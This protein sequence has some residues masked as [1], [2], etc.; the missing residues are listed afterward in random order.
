[1]TEKVHIIE[2]LGET[3]LLLPVL[4]NTAL[5]ANDRAKYYFTLLQTARSQADRPLAHPVT[6]RAERLASGVTDESLDTT[7]ERAA[8]DPAGMYQIPKLAEVLAA[9]MRE[10]DLML[11]PVR[12]ESNG[13]AAEF[14]R[15]LSGLRVEPP[16]SDTVDGA[17]IEGMC[18]GSRDRG[19][20]LHLL[21]MD[22]HKALNRM[23]AR[24]ASE[25]LD[26]CL[27]YG[28]TD[29]DRPLVRAFMR[30]VNRT[31]P[32]KFDHP[33][34][35]TTATHSGARLVLQND[36]GTTDAHVL[37]IH[38]EDRTAAITCTDV[39][40]Q[41]L[42]F[43]QSLFERFTVEWDDTRSRKDTA[44]EQG[45]YHLSVG[46]YRAADRGGLE[47]FLEFLGSR[48]VF[49][50][51]WNRARKRLRN[52][53]RKGEAI[54]L[55]KWAADHDCGHMGFLKAGGELLLYETLQV[56]AR[57]QYHPGQS[58]EDLLGAKPADDYLKFVLRTCTEGLL[59]G[60]PEV[61]VRD[62]IRAELL[63]YVRTGQQSLFDI[64][65]D[66]AAYIVEIAQGLYTA[67]LRARQSPDP[68]P[69][70]ENARRAK[71]WESKA[72]AL[73]NQARQEAKAGEPSEFFCSLVETADDIADELE[74]AAFHLTLL[75][76]D[77]SQTRLYSSLQVLSEL[78]M[79]G[80]QEYLKAVETARHLHRSAARE[81]MG[82]FLDSI[83]RIMLVE[84]DADE[85]QRGVESALAQSSADFKA[86]YQFAET[87]RNLEQAADSL[88]RCGLH[89]RD[90]IMKQVMAA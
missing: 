24:I 56:V 34:L 5:A 36:I 49:L 16:S 57:G 80:T 44:V 59:K 18:S 52:F 55:L 12:M 2:G 61:F 66:H 89:L 30:G 35:G 62:A 43:F 33:G 83:H 8:R 60:E 6:L 32:L 64:A 54:R 13:T 53:V 50:I 78:L 14:D 42:M 20:S 29:A 68:A 85:A 51:D 82:D 58:L 1:M 26:G 72:D 37:V 31:A 28:L 48:L 39:H 9:L 73:V 84:R 22:L 74:D 40:L 46:R 17:L 23:Q 19:D 10:I 75:P 3:A 47:A 4:I 76:D 27:A 69:R 15:R 71:E 45:V 86:L 70:V 11:S 88:L 65:S 41:R 21:V 38:V 90:Y 63:N 81:E 67:V 25:N 79:Q 7:V 77:P 87:A